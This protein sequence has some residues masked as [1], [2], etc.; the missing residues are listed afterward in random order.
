LFFYD[1]VLK[2]ARFFETVEER[3][4]ANALTGVHLVAFGSRT[5]K[6]TWT[7]ILPGNFNGSGN[8]DLLFYDRWIH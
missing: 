5:E 7:N 6:A 1:P 8:T 4:Q 2:S 3:N